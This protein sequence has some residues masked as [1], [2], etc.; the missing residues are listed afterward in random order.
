VDS[1]TG[2]RTLQYGFKV[3]GESVNITNI[4]SVTGG[5][6]VYMSRAV[7]LSLVDLIRGKYGLNDLSGPVGIVTAISGA[8]VEMGIDPMFLLQMAALI[9]INVGLFNLLPL[10]ALDGG[11]FVFLVVELIR[12]KPIKP[13]VEGVF[14]F[15]GFALLM[16]LMVVI[17]VKDVRNIFL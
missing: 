4:A 5:E 14:H 16:V 10:P 9:T 1:E 2:L 13:E 8:S 15:V 3:L 7:I 11:R 6:F 12:R 17:T